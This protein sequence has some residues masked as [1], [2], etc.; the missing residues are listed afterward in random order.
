M[1][2]ESFAPYILDPLRR[3]ANMNAQQSNLAKDLKKA[4]G[5]AEE[6]QSDWTIERSMN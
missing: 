2:S 6:N 3:T 1:Y 5:Q 4:L